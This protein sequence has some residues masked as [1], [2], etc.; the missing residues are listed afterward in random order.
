[1]SGLDIWYG[2]QG[3]YTQDQGKRNL[4]KWQ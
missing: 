3:Y 1:L 2:Y 4:N